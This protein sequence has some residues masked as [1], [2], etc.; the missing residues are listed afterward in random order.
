MSSYPLQYFRFGM[1]NTDNCVAASASSIIPTHDLGR[2]SEKWY[3]NYIASGAYQIVNV[4]NNQLLTS[5]GN[6]V[7]LSNN[8][9][10]ESQKWNIEGVE[11]DYEEYY[12]YYRITSNSD[13]TKSLTYSEDNGFFLAQY[14]GDGFQ[15]YK[16]NLDGLEGFAANCKTSQGEKAGT[17]GGLLG[18]VVYSN[19]AEE[20]EAH[21]K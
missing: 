12:L 17:I 21:L 13:K 18:Q 15:K 3:L 14:T 8:S 11:K 1:S 2:A 16:L 4:S 9:N 7:F 20:L 5:N 6:N 19:N 10:S